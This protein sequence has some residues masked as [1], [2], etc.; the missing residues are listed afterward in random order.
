MSEFQRCAE[1]NASEF[2]FFSFAMHSCTFTPRDHSVRK[3]LSLN[4]IPVVRS[5]GLGRPHKAN[6]GTELRRFPAEREDS[7]SRAGS[8]EPASSF[9]VD[10][11]GVRKSN[12]GV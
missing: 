5:G 11:N 9:S 6:L 4:K 1:R 2:T 10:V 12:H 7:T 3:L 8:T